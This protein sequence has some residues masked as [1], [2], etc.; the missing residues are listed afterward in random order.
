MKLLVGKPLKKCSY[1]KKAIANFNGENT[2][3]ISS[4]LTLKVYLG[5]NSAVLK[6]RAFKDDRQ[7]SKYV[8]ICN[9]YT[10]T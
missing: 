6:R 5:K 2:E 10:Q 8:P 4:L 9:N 1:S 3:P 7:G